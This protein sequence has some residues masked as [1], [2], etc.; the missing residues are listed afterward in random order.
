MN[1]MMAETRSALVS[2]DEVSSELK[3]A[4]FELLRR[5]FDGVSESQFTL[6][7]SE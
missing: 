4:M 2:R 5:H 6:D 1:T 7:L 3:C